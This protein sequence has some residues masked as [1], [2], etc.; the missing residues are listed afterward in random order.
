MRKQYTATLESGETLCFSADLVE[1]SAPVYL[2]SDDG[3]L[4]GTSLQ[5]ADGQHRMRGV[6]E[7]LVR[8]GYSDDRSDAVSGVSEVAS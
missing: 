1:A 8:R 7:A 5:T 6:A 3:E 2:V 4:V